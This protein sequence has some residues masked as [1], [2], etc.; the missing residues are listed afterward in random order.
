VSFLKSFSTFSFFTF[1][2]RIFGFL[3]DVIN[4]RVLGAGML[5]DA[6]FI[7]FRLPNL[8]RSLFAEGAMNSAFIPIY[9]KK[10][11]HCEQDAPQFI[12]KIIFLIGIFLIFFC[13]LAEIF[14]PEILSVIAPGFDKT[15]E[16]FEIGIQLGRIMFPFL[17]F[18]TITAIYGCAIQSHG[19]FIPTSSYP[20]IMNIVLITA[21]FIPFLIPAFSLAYGV[22]VSGILQLI[23]LICSAKYYKIQIGFPIFDKN[24]FNYDVKHFFRKLLPS[25][26]TSCVTR[27]GITIDTMIASSTVGAVS[28]IYYSDRL[29][30]LPLSIV[31]VTLANVLLPSL[32][33]ITSK[34]NHLKKN[35]L[36]IEHKE[37]SDKLKIIQ[38]R[39]FEFAFILI[40]PAT[41]GLYLL[42]NDIVALL[43]GNDN[44]KF[45]QESLKATSNF[46]KILC[47]AL[48]ANILNNIFNS[49]LFANHITK[50]TTK[51]AIYTL[52]LNL[53]INFT[54]FYKFNYGYECVAVA[55]VLS[56]YFN[57]IV[58]GVFCKENGFLHSIE[59]FSRI[60]YIFFTNMALSL[61]ISTLNLLKNIFLIPST[62]KWNLFLII[63]IVTVIYVYFKILNYNGKF[64]LNDFKKLFID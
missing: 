56:S 1:I 5:S 4:A 18:I 24:F 22:I 64:K 27:I 51:T 19:N 15:N 31:G 29:Y 36:Y 21:S 42:S 41:I 14:M 32:S 35:D 28:Y 47:I 25:I 2:S 11:T 58:L 13:G 39:I 23:F 16:Y 46:L 37:L 34:M 49:I 63:E 7:A 48:P 6:F 53:T 44:G 40:L 52:I 43:F 62:F 26:L 60:K 45:S 57:A 12:G 50:F 3:R 10:L 61:L 9:S 54:L 59:D 55:T 30:Q 38:S 17:F 33:R 20:I 8:F